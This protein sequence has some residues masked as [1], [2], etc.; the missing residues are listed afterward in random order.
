MHG[1][2][3]KIEK[4][5]FIFFWSVKLINLYCEC[6]EYN[7]TTG[8]SSKPLHKNQIKINM[9]IHKTM[10]TQGAGFFFRVAGSQ[11]QI[12]DV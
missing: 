2:Y 5:I 8:K 11:N 6:F 4:K 3:I 10:D 1:T 12:E 7:F 9:F